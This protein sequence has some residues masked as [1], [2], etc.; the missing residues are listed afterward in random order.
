LHG[1]SLSDTAEGCGEVM[2]I[3]ELV[4]KALDEEKF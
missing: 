2:R 3:P 4:N 1:E